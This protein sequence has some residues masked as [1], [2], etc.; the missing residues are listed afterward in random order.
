MARVRRKK[1]ESGTRH[2]G[3]TAR[4]GAVLL[5]LR[6]ALRRAE[7]CRQTLSEMGY[8]SQRWQEI[9]KDV[10]PELRFMVRP[11]MLDTIISYL[12]SAG[13]PVSRA[14]LIHE[15]GAQRAGSL[16]R[17]RQS[18]TV[19]LQCG[20]LLLYPENKIGLPNWKGKG[21]LH[22]AKWKE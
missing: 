4:V 2:H 19:N 8:S 15:L 10:D 18:I 17:I 14:S 5:D 21:P 20:N 12:Q 22:S 3:P 1:L 11:K 9:V 16:Q 7:R 6:N 13:E